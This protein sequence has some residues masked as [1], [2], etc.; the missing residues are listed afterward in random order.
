MTFWETFYNLCILNNTK[1]N[2]VAK[3]LGFSSAVCT[4]WKKGLQNPSYDKLSKIAEYFG[5]TTDYLITGKQNRIIE[6]TP[7]AQFVSQHKLR[8]IPL[9]ESVSAGYGAYADSQIIGYEAAYIESDYEAENTI[10]IIVKGDSMYPKIED[11]DIVIV[12]KQ[13]FF[14]NG[15]IVVAIPLDGTDNGFVKRA[16]QTPEK[17]TLESINA[18]YPPM[19]FKGTEMNNIA[20]VGVVKKIIKNI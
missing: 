16:F 10:A 1:P 11:G 17:L 18:N 14:E 6:E 8:Q 20:I 7:N 4:Q 2:T 3:E 9:F 12:L 13:D 5:V 15:D 19:V